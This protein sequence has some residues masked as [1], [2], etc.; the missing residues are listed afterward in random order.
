MLLT[1]LLYSY[2]TKL[3]LLL[4]KLLLYSYYTK[5]Y[6]EPKHYHYFPFSHQS[7]YGIDMV[8]CLL[9]AQR[10]DMNLTQIIATIWA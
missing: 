9:M 10:T 5:I 2:Y 8:H 3:L 7:K 4:Y 1:L 6:Q